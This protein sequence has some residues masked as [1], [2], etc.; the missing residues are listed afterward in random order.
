LNTRWQAIYLKYVS[1]L[2]QCIS[3][4]NNTVFIQAIGVSVENR[5]LWKSELS[6]IF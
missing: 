2:H 3:T 6:Y 5:N 4:E 1:D